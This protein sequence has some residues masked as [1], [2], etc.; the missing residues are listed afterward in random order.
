MLRHTLKVNEL[1]RYRNLSR[2]GKTWKE[3]DYFTKF[4]LTEVRRERNSSLLEALRFKN[5]KKE[6]N[7]YDEA[8]LELVRRMDELFPLSAARESDEMV[9]CNH[10]LRDTKL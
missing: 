3:V 5:F 10:L 6:D 2:D 8:L 7:D 9:K 1:S 4:F